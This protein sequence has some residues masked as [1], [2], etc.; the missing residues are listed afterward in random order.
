MNQNRRKVMKQAITLAAAGSLG[1]PLMSR[2]AAPTVI[3][4]GGSAW[5][6]HY[7]AYI[8]MK[9]G[10]MAKYGIDL[11]WQAFSTSSARMAAVMAG[12]VDIAGTGV[13]SA[14]A[15]MA[16]GAKQFQLIATPNN[17]GRAEGLLARE[18][19]KSVADLKG[20]KIGVTYASSAHV[21]LLDVLSQAGI[22]PDKD[23]SIINLPATELLTAYKANQIDAAGAWTPTFDRIRALPGTRMLFD[24]SSF[25]L[26]KSYKMSPGPDV[27]LTRTGFGKENP[28]AV[29]AF[30]Q[31]IFEANALLTQKPEEAAKILLELTSLS[32]EEQLGVIRQTEWFTLADQKALM[33]DPGN[34]VVGL[35][36]LAEMLLKLKQ[37]DSMPQVRQWV[38]TTYL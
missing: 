38:N 3:N 26:Y 1:F 6:G 17:F 5:L 10:L 16:S 20:K 2:A 35:Q 31:A 18:S 32:M 30:M 7:S 24:D 23:V 21:L 12:N 15:L 33:S 22:N 37:I 9:T 4:Y 14:L 36:K 27:L 13:V 11:R 8:A 28:A 29:K 34:F 25:S 19:I